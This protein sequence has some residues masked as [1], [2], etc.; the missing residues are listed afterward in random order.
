MATTTQII[1]RKDR[2]IHQ[3]LKAQALV[4]LCSFAAEARRILHEIDLAAEICPDVG[5]KLSRLV[6]SR[7]QWNEHDDKLGMVLSEIDF[8]LGSVIDL[9]EGLED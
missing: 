2:L 5:E 8:Q 3:L 7:N 4:G 1:D 6:A 9:A